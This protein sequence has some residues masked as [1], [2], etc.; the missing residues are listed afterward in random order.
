MVVERN[1]SVLDFYYDA[2]FSLKQRINDGM[3][4]DKKVSSE[5]DFDLTYRRSY[6]LLVLDILYDTSRFFEVVFLR[7]GIYIDTYIQYT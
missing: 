2:Y 6:S 5:S 4:M 3:S 1:K 7:F